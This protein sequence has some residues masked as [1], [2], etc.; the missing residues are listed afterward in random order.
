MGTAL[1]NT[2]RI[3]VSD[4]FVALARR[5]DRPLTRWLRA[6]ATREALASGRQVGI[7]GM[8]LTGGF[9]LAAA[10]DTAIG[11]AV[12]SQ[13]SVPFCYGDGTIDLAMSADTLDELAARAE[14]GFCVRALRFSRDMVSR[15]QRLRFIGEALP[16]SVV[17]EVPSRRLFDHSVLTS[18]V[19]ADEDSPL[20]VAL[21]ET[22]EYLH[23]RL[24]APGATT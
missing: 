5:A 1:R 23:A 20:G 11:A 7:V 16:N 12:A 22:V 6:L 13:P 14:A 15:R 21:R 9:A 18:A 10:V 8:C 17:V 2:W 4:Q 24:D 19:G 3:C